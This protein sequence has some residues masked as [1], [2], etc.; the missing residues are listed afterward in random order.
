MF[1]TSFTNIGNGRKTL[2]S[3]QT[4]YLHKRFFAQMHLSCNMA[5][6]LSIYSQFILILT[7]IAQPV[8]CSDEQAI[9]RKSVQKYLENHVIER[10]HANTELECVLYCL[11]NASCTSINYKISSSSKG[12][13]ELNNRSLRQTL[14]VAETMVHN[15]EFNYLHIS[16]KVR[17]LT[18][19]L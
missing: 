11:R 12:L 17:Q 7:L 8:K 9:F 13:C 16:E 3:D 6:F 4:T 19:E 5:G 1:S 14:D 10:R 2:P 15:P 18:Y